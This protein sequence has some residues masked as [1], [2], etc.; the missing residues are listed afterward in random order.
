M[1]LTRE[2]TFLAVLVGLAQAAFR[3]LSGSL[4][5]T[6]QGTFQARRSELATLWSDAWPFLLATLVFFGW[7][8]VVG[9]IWGH[10][11]IEEARGG[12]SFTSPLIAFIEFTTALVRSTGRM[13]RIWLFEIV[14]LLLLVGAGVFA[15]RRS[16]ATEHE[17]I[18]WLVYTALL[19][20]LGRNVWVEDYGFLRLATE[21]YILGTLIL[22]GARPRWLSRWAAVAAGGWWVFLAYDF[23]RYR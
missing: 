20:S 2:T 10:L 17:K 1:T 4:R 5:T 8:F 11:A 15:L 21:V 13:E 19:F 9:L 14:L 12:A 16:T 6:R 22:L 3:W 18:T 7:Q 23:I